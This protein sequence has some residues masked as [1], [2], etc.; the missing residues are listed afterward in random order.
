MVHI[1]ELLLMHAR[2]RIRAG[3]AIQVC[4]TATLNTSLTNGVVANERNWTAG[5]ARWMARDTKVYVRYER[6]VFVGDSIRCVRGVHGDTCKGWSER[7]RCRLCDLDSNLRH[8]N[9]SRDVGRS[10]QKVAKPVFNS[11]AGVGMLGIVRACDG[12]IL[13]LL[14]P[15]AQSR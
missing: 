6:L 3:S 15:S 2:L 13:G 12:S 10:N 5:T 14:L 11:L 1:K 4:T 9:G 8:R 7:H